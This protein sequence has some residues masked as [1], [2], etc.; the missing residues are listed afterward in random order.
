MFPNW[1]KTRNDFVQFMYTNYEKK[2]LALPKI[3]EKLPKERTSDELYFLSMYLLQIDIF[4][5]LPTS[6]E[7]IIL[8]N[9][10]TRYYKKGDIIHR[11]FDDPVEF[12]AVVFLGEVEI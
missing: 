4:Q 3:C 10:Q 2:I 6:I 7:E 11:G 12:M 1:L 9:I 8:K 5:K